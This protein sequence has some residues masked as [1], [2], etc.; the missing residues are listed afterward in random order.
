MGNIIPYIWIFQPRK[1][2]QRQWIITIEHASWHLW[3][4]RCNAFGYGA[5]RRAVCILCF[6]VAFKCNTWGS[7][8]CTI[9]HW[10]SPIC[11]TI[12][13]ALHLQWDVICHLYRVFMTGS[14][15]LDPFIWLF[16]WTGNNNYCNSVY[17]H[18]FRFI[19]R[20]LSSS[21]QLWYTAIRCKCKMAKSNAA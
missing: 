5:D 19:G 20:S 2:L 18:R 9:D 10:P 16:T 17:L 11:A 3:I 6:D 21:S 8:A 4:Y 7:H 14:F 15:Q 1:H 12:V 13:Q